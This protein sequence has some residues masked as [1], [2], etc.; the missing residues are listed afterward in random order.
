MGLKWSLLKSE[1]LP[2][3]FFFNEVGGRKNLSIFSNHSTKQWPVKNTQAAAEE[4]LKSRREWLQQIRPSPEAC[5]NKHLCYSARTHTHTPRRLH[6]EKCSRLK[7]CVETGVVIGGPTPTQGHNRDKVT[8]QTKWL[9]TVCSKL[10]ALESTGN[11]HT[12]GQP[13]K[14][15]CQRRH[16]NAPEMKFIRFTGNHEGVTTTQR[17]TGYKGTG[18]KPA[19]RNHFDQKHQT[20]FNPWPTKKAQFD[21]LSG[22]EHLFECK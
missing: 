13:A 4:S 22:P 1:L 14:V 21:P 3:A 11:N 15:N 20:R 17:H 9:T 16:Q 2:V 19:G 10:S 8:Q 5:I 18:M 7:S 6:L 12:H